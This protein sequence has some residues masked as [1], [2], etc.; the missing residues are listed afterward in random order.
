[1][2]IE[3]EDGVKIIVCI[4]EIIDPE[5]PAAAF[6]VNFEA[7][8]AILPPGFKL[9]ISDYDEVA[10]EAALQIKDAHSGKITVL[11]LGEESAK[12]DLKHC[13][14]MG[15]DEGVLLLDPL[16]DDFDSSATAQAL[17]Q[18]IKKLGD[19]DLILCGRQEGEW[20]AGQVGSGIAHFLGI[21][22]VT[23]AGRIEIKDGKAI[24]ERVVAEGR[25]VIEVPLPALVTASNEIGEPRYPSLRRIMVASKKE[26]LTWNAQDIGY[27]AK[28][29][30]KL[31]KL[32]VPVHEGKCN[33]IEGETPEEMGVNLTLKLR[34]LNLI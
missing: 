18:A 16:F 22:C 20:D 9:V 29:R 21:P 26:I 13:M 30:N 15:A 1:M 33:F 4:K 28:A 19:F 34:E 17:T 25:D 23:V 2:N 32:F 24:V 10:V 8:R 12:D 31:V 27:S 14:A 11:T 3:Q 5:V 6:K 7:K